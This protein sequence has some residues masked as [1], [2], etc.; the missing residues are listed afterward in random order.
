M[1][2]E[3]RKVLTAAVLNI[4]ETMF[5]TF[6]EPLEGRGEQEEDP[7]EEA[8]ALPAGTDPPRERWL[9]SDIGFSG[10]QSGSLTV[11][12]PW[13]M[14]ETMTKNFLGLEEEV[15]EEQMADMAGELANMV[16]GNF[17]S[18]LDKKSVITLSPPV[19]R[20]MDSEEKKRG[21]LPGDLVLDFV[22]EGQVVTCIL[23]RIVI[24]S[25]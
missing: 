17:F 20:I 10:V 24:P 2:E 9:S 12:L 5:F 13:E 4:F 14:G 7:P 18:A 25:A 3:V 21:I 16:C 22:S 15:N 6:L 19:T 8:E 11:C 23:R 1:P